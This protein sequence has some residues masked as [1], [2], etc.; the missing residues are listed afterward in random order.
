MHYVPVWIQKEQWLLKV[1]SQSEGHD[2]SH[3][4]TKNTKYIRGSFRSSQ[5][6]GSQG[7]HSSDSQPATL[8]IASLLDV[9]AGIQFSVVFFHCPILISHL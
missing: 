5:G 8:F 6:S 4:N 2:S 3:L 9:A 7:N 1:T